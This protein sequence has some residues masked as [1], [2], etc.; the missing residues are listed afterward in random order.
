MS[1]DTKEAVIKWARHSCWATSTATPRQGASASP[2]LAAAVASQIDPVTHLA[3]GIPKVTITQ[4]A[5]IC[6]KISSR[7][8]SPFKRDV[9]TPSAPGIEAMKQEL[10]V[11]GN[12]A[13]WQVSGIEIV[14]TE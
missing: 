12:A 4:L 7:L 13:N 10:I 8:R 1:D 9:A 14:S 5:F 3:V 2:T 11:A 6:F